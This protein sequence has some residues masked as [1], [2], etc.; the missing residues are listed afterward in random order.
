MDVRR[1]MLMK[2]TSSGDSGGGSTTS[3]SYT[4]VLNSQWQKSSTIS[5]PDSNTYD[6]VYESYSN[7]GVN[8]SAA[9]MY[10]DISGLSEFSFYIRSY[11][12]S[13]YDYI[14]V[15]QLDQT[16]TNDSS[17]SNTTLVKAHTRGNPQPSTVIPS[18]TLV[19]FT[20]I[21]KGS[22][23]ITVL[24]R[25][26]SA[27]H[28]YDDRGYVLIPKNQGSSGGGDI[29]IDTT[30]VIYYT[31]SDGNIVT[32][33]R[34]NVFNANIVSN[35]YINGQGIIS[36]DGPVTTIGE[37][38]FYNCSS[39]TSVNIGDGVTEIGKSAFY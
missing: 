35:N 16:I 10:I 26:D 21:D 30:N 37:S 3:G 33:H 23:R 31:S 17:Y 12:E 5:N 14:M 13:L 8:S 32:P 20:G 1:R 11:A 4:V 34:T 7:K 18:Y 2:K 36:F 39:L 19:E 22:H 6:G 38:A 29:E 15:S 25:K 27:T 28:N 24:Y 9:V